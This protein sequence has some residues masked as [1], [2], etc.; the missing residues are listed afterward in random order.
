MLQSFLVPG[1]TGSKVTWK[2]ATAPKDLAPVHKDRERHQGRSPAMALEQS[3]VHG[4]WDVAR[5]IRDHRLAID[6]KK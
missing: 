5:S 4:L 3:G 1:L 2:A 6:H